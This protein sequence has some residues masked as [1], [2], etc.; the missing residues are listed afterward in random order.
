M[1]LLREYQPELR[2]LLTFFSPSGYE[3]RKN[4][5]GADDVFYLPLDTARNARRFMDIVQPKAV[6]F[7][8]YEF[9]YHFMREAK[10][11]QIPVLLFSAIFR[12]NQLFFKPYGGFYRDILKCYTKIFVQNRR[13]VE[14]LQQYDIRN[15]EEVG[16]TR[17]DRVIAIAEQ[18]KIITE[19]EQF[20]AG[21]P[22]MVIGSSWPADLTVLLPIIESFRELKF[23]VAPHEIKESDIES[24]MR[25][26]K[27]PA[28][29]YSQLQSTK[30]DCADILVIDNIG[31]LSSLY[32][33][34]DF[35]YV[36]GAFGRG[37]HNILE[38][39]VFGIP[40]FFGPNYEKFK[41]AS[42][43]IHAEGAFSVRTAQEL[44]EKLTALLKNEEARKNC[45]SMN[46]R[47]VYGQRG[48][49]ETV[50][51]ALIRELKSNIHPS[52]AQ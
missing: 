45:S 43:L 6:L 9:W 8:K 11:R 36:G 25:T 46:K 50:Y 3:I 17:F 27:R 24:L 31:L 51:H 41:E 10:R 29:R 16:D 12:D 34:A 32:G 5:A 40:V 38:A 20:K 1:E 47:Y 21:R 30:P 14:L 39:A 49:S 22:L 35:A 42:D 37:L 15:V 13:S 19:V 7:V 28:V 52:E 48:A 2:V 18:R 23:I 33:Y 26:L 4:Y 44:S